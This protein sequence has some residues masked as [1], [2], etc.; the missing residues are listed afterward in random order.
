[1]S[2]AQELFLDH[3]STTP[4]HPDALGV[5]LPYFGNHFGTPGSPSRL[6]QKARDALEEARSRVAKLITARHREIIF[7][8]SGTE[9]N[10]LA[11]LGGVRARGA[12]GKHIVTSR[13]EHASVLGACRHLEREGFRV[14]CVPVDRCGRVDPAAVEDALEDDTLLISIMHA[15]HAV[16]TLQPIGEI[17]AIA[18]SRGI[19]FHV[20][21]VQSAGKVPL[22]VE[23]LPVDLMSISSHKLYGPKGVGA[24]YIRDDAEIS[25]V[26][27]GLSQE[28]GIRPGTENIP[29][30]VGFGIACA[31]AE[32]D[33]DQNSI[34]VA[35][36]RDSLEGQV[37]TTVGGAW[38]NAS[39]ALRLPHITSLSFEDISG[40]SLASYLDVMGIAASSTP[41][42]SRQ[43]EDLSY[44]LEAM[45]VNG[46][47][48]CGA[49]RLSPGW[50]NKEREIKHT[51]ECLKTA[52][53][54]IREFSVA[55]EGKDLGFFTFGDR[56]SVVRSLAGLEGRGIPIVLM[57]RPENLALGACSPIVLCS[58]AK[59]LET[60]GAI[61]GELG[62][63]PRGIHRVK[64]RCRPMERKE[65]AFWEK[66]EKVK[67]GVK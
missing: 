5:M 23:D 36:L 63:E 8:S 50:E 37:L 43:G 54:R 47:C 42:L 3:A 52:A 10:N 39:A 18:R 14:T 31:V 17:G 61:L 9:S 22:N 60:I 29:G 24:L 57:P 34:L 46:S 51:V 33:L 53:L 35:S 64:P 1:M 28:R 66:V 15:N 30:I 11:I 32:R 67:K 48:P 45:D 16:G 40:D 26:T 27:F 20:D 59:D 56:D 6:G 13:V 2:H 58:L 38:V 12:K 65:Q 19:T 49:L 4:L 62:E 7:T 44:V 55:S 41:S 25:P 21:A